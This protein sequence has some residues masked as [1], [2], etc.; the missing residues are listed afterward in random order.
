MTTVFKSAYPSSVESVSTLQ[1]LVGS[2]MQTFVPV[3]SRHKNHFI[4]D[5]PDDLYIDADRELVASVLSGM[6]SAVL[7]NA[8]DSCIRLSAKLYGNVVLVHIKDYNS[9]NYFPI[10]NGL[11]QLQ[12]LAEKVGGSV[13]VTSQRQNVTTLA[14]SFPN[15]PM[16]A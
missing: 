9:F 7:K 13:S 16:A 3:A 4:N 14:F 10:E 6:M 2:L 1:Q 12:P 11:H 5:I 15:M 8:K